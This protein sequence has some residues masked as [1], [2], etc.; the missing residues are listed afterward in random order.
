MSKT[1]LILFASAADANLYI[2]VSIDNGCQFQICSLGFP[3]M[4][5]QVI[6]HCL[7]IKERVPFLN[8]Q[9]KALNIQIPNVF[10]KTFKNS[11]GKPSI[12]DVLLFF[13]VL[14]LLLVPLI[15]HHLQVILLAY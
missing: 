2:T 1:G 12:P 8:L 13:H 14:K 9:F 7:C 3:F 6:I 11:A 15:L 4:G 5:G 10:Q